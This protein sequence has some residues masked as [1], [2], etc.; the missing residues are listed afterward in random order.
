MTLR[1]DFDY[2][3][4]P[5]ACLSVP[6]WHQNIRS[7]QRQPKLINT[8]SH[9]PLDDSSSEASVCLLVSGE[10]EVETSLLPSHGALF[11]I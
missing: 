7:L 9:G 3:Y 5:D 4:T 11:Y 1:V 8:S 10:T 2:Q 6:D